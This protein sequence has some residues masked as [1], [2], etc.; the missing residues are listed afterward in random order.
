MYPLFGR[1]ASDLSGAALRV[2][3]VLSPFSPHTEPSRELDSMDCS[4]HSESEQLPRKSDEPQLSPPCVLQESPAS[5]Q[6]HGNSTAADVRPSQQG[7]PESDGTF[8]VSILVERAMHLSLKG[9]LSIRTQKQVSS[10][11]PY[12]VFTE[13]SGH[14]RPTSMVSFLSNA[15]DHKFLTRSPYVTL[16]ASL[17]HLSTVQSPQQINDSSL[18]LLTTLSIL[19]LHSIHSGP[20]DAPRVY[21]SPGNS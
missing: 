9:M 1:N 3:V 5:T 4:S 14:A 7:P 20:Q 15:A 16:S 10:S 13:L 17:S 8:A 21:K 2:H 6:V 11:S 19:L 18:K 12:S